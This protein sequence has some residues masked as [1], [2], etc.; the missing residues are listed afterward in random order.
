MMTANSR[1]EAVMRL[2]LGFLCT[3]VTACAADDYQ[4]AGVERAAGPQAASA[5]QER[6]FVPVPQV[7]PLP[8]AQFE[9][10]SGGCEPRFANGTTGTCINGKP[11]NGFGFRNDKGELVCACFDVAGGCPDAQACNSR[12]RMCMPRDKIDVQRTPTK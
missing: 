8:P 12:R 7:A 5:R 9:Y 6:A 4:A 10:G 2:L 11:C 1:S 3:L